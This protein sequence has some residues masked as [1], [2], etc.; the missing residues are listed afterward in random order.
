MP[1]FER[2]SGHKVT[3]TWAGT[4]DIKKRLKAGEIFDLVIMSSQFD[5]RADQAGQARPGSRV[6]LAKTGIGVAVRAGAPKPD[7]SSAEALKQTLLAAKSS[8]IPP[9]RAA[10]IW[11][12]CSS[13]WVSPTK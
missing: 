8:A 2:A 11:Q 3:T 7:I 10:S 5:R 6:D 9:G 1:Q 4:V 13:A 12:A